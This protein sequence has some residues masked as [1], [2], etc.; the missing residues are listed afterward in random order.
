MIC[1]RWR[2]DYGRRDFRIV[3]KTVTSIPDHLFWAAEVLAKRLDISRNEL[4]TRAIASY[5]EANR[6]LGVRERLDSVYLAE[7]S[8]LDD[9]VNKMQFD[10]LFEEKW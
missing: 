10:S 9:D 6:S 5:V 2:F 1:S 8:R 7:S 3:K 4:Y